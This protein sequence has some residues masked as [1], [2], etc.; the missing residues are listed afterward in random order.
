MNELMNHGNS[1]IA[2]LSDLAQEAQ[3]YAKSMV[4][5]LLQLG[6]VLTEAKP[7]VKHGQWEQWIQE[8]AGCSNRY[9]QMF[10]QAY[11]RFGNNPAISQIKERGKVFKMLAL[12]AGTEEQFLSEN[13]VADMTTK[14]VEAAVRRVREEMTGELKAEQTAR[15]AAERKVA[16]L[17]AA[18]PKIP[19]SV[20]AELAEQA[21]KIKSQA[22]ELARLAETGTAAID[23]ANKMRK[24]IT[25]LQRELDDQNQMLDE[26][27]QDYDRVRSELLALQSAAAKGDAERAPADELTIDVFASAVR[28]FIGSCARMPHMGRSFALMS[29]TEKNRYEELLATVESWAKNARYAMNT[30]SDMEG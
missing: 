17:V 11:E 25:A 28:Q 14:E 19:D 9:A 3:H 21:E 7:L 23:E 10:M 6:R 20:S 2:I 15:A 18:P 29:A 24:Q 5:N 30:I 16:E 13:N 1:E 27:Q 12:P 8:N 22:A 4:T 26:A